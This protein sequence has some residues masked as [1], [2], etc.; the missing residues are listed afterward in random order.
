MMNEKKLLWNILNSKD[1]SQDLLSLDKNGILDDLLPELTALKGVDVING[2]GHKDNFLHTLQVIK[3]T[4][5]ASSNPWLILVAILHDCGKATTKRFDREKGW[6]FQNHELVSSRIVK[7]IFNRFDLDKTQLDYVSKLVEYHGIA[8]ELTKNGV[9]DSAIRRF[10][11]ELGDWVDDLLTFCKCD[12][13]TSSVIKRQRFQ[14][15]LDSLKERID[16]VKRGDEASKW[17]CPIDGNFIM[18]ELDIKPGRKL[19]Q[20]KAEIERAIKNGEIEDNF[21]GAYNYLLE[22]KDKF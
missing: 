19:G 5:Q 14:I 21:I 18:K 17:R 9:T 12:M 7:N 8:K 3:Q 15:E 1:P 6:T 10:S 20:I 2:Q 13:T 16:E 22:I 11:T 4:S